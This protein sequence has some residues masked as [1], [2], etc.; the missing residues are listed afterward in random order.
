MA[1]FLSPGSEHTLEMKFR[2]GL[3]PFLSEGEALAS[4]TA[5]V[6]G[7]PVAARVD[8]DSVLWDV[9][10]AA[11]AAPGARLLSVVSITTDGTPPREDSRSVINYVGVP[12]AIPL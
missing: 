9:S 7:S 1:R 6:N 11:D 8:G 4:A 12:A 10:V 5:T 3:V 2:H